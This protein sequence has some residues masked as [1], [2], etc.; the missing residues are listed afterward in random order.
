M[1]VRIYRLCRAS[2][3]LAYSCYLPRRPWGGYILYT[4]LSSTCSRLHAIVSQQFIEFCS[5][6]ALEDNLERHKNVSTLLKNPHPRGICCPFADQ[7][8]FSGRVATKSAS[9]RRY[10]AVE[11][12][13]MA[14]DRDLTCLEE[15]NTALL[16][17]LE[18]RRHMPSRTLQG[19]DNGETRVK[20]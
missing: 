12:E 9:F 6:I 8:T 3:R 19:Y 15:S 5:E 4:C 10:T 20:L 2:T 11:N 14:V 13:M 7:P 16:A 18:Q 17:T 1:C